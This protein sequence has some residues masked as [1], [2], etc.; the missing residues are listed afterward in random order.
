MLSNCSLVHLRPTSLSTFL[1]TTMAHPACFHHGASCPLWSTAT[2]LPSEIKTTAQHETKH[3][4]HN[5]ERQRLGRQLHLLSA[6]NGSCPP[7][8]SSSFSSS[9]RSYDCKDG[10]DEVTACCQA[11]PVPS[12]HRAESEVHFG[13]KWKCSIDWSVG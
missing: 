11:T 7:F 5:A 8:C 6:L 2:C 1:F 9:R 13:G 3:Q 4:C 10:K 12:H